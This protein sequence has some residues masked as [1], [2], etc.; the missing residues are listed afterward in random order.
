MM[1]LYERYF[2][3][4]Y[5][6]VFT[7]ESLCETYLNVC[8]NDFSISVYSHAQLK[9]H[10][11][12]LPWQQQILKDIHIPKTHRKTLTNKISLISQLDKI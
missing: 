4:D 7:Q 12:W 8:I 9:Y 11:R 5:I 6:N 10:T 1:S 2:I 3:E